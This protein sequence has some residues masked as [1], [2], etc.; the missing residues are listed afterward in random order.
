[1]P[2]VNQMAGGSVSPTPTSPI[3]PGQAPGQVN[4][5]VLLAMSGNKNYRIP[6]KSWTYSTLQNNVTAKFD[7]PNVVV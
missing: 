5:D 1:M 6:S 2:N 3:S 7:N 4:H